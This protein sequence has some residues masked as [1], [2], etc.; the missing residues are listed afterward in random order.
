MGLFALFLTVGSFSLFIN[1]IYG[2]ILD[3]PSRILLYFKGMEYEI[4]F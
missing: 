1:S 2:K 3:V 4:D